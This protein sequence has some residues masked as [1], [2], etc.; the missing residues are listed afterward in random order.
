VVSLRRYYQILDGMRTQVRLAPSLHEYSGKVL[1][2][3]Q[4]T[5]VLRPRAEEPL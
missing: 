5:F 2:L 3:F 1:P 4:P